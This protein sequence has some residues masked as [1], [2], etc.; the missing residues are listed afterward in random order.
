MSL[1]KGRQP[2]IERRAIQGAAQDNQIDVLQA[3]QGEWAAKL[4]IP[5][6]AASVFQGELREPSAAL[7]QR[8]QFFCLMTDEQPVYGSCG[9]ENF[10]E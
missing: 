4:E 10:R 9:H 3:G 1:Y 2:T 6:E 7:T 8:T 5:V